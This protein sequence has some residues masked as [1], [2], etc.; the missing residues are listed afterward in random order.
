M[1]GAPQAWPLVARFWDEESNYFNEKLMLSAQ[2]H[3]EDL[4]NSAT[5][6]LTVLVLM[7]NLP[8]ELLL[9]MPLTPAQAETVCRQAVDNFDDD[10]C[11]ELCV[12]ILQSILMRHGGE[13][14]TIEA[15]FYD[16]KIHIHRDK[17]F[18]ESIIEIS[19]CHFTNQLIKYIKESEDDISDYA[20][21]LVSIGK[22][23]SCLSYWDTEA[24]V[25]CIMRL[26]HSGRNNQ[27]IKRACLDI[28]DTVFLTNPITIRSLA[29]LLDNV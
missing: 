7:K 27:E 6:M 5:D 14:H 26:F 9:N 23:L 22:A 29:D 3:I 16:K 4:Q 12:Q 20:E 10:R 24:Y 15:L 1:L 17:V 19:G 18:L 2:S 28:W 21:I 25:A 11:H 8:I 13:L